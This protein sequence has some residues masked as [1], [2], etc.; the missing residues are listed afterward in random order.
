VARLGQMLARIEGRICHSPLD[1]LSPF[2]VPILLEIGKER[3][4]GQA[5]EMVLA[6]AEEDLIAEAMA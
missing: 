1:H 4:P 5:G 2:S 3:S 6:E